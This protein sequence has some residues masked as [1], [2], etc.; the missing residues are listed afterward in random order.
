MSYGLTDDTD[1][2]DRVIQMVDRI[3]T[4]LSGED[5]AEAHTALTLAVACQIIASD[6]NGG[7]K[8][9]VAQARTFAGQLDLFLKREDIVKF[10]KDGII[11]VTVSA[12][13]DQ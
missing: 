4:V 1:A 5:M 8:G 11:S 7:L 9:R 6:E 13:R 10:I 3:N 2:R 12:R